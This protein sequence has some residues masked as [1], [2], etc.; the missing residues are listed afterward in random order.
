MERL[1]T[2]IKK[3]PDGCCEWI[4]KRFKN[5]YGQICICL[6][7]KKRR[8]LLAHRVMFE[9]HYGEELGELNALHRC[10]RPWCVNPEHLFKGTQ[11][12]NMQDMLSKHREKPTK[13]ELS[14]KA[15]LTELKV[16]AIREAVRMGQTHAK[17][18]SEF[19]ISTKQVT[20]IINRQQW[21]HVP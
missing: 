21:S 13:G 3:R 6:E 16:I 19:G 8:Y 14:G 11:T 20:V 4:G 9:L 2:K 17:V 18:A 1:L 5:G 12:V 7:P 15:K 10:D